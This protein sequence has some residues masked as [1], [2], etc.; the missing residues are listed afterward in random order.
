MIKFE[1]K[2]L[3]MQTV[4]ALVEAAE[5]IQDKFEQHPELKELYYDGYCRLLDTIVE[6][7]P[8][9]DTKNLSGG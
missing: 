2:T 5:K 8:R 4:T 7:K 3:P 1:R 9:D 6:F